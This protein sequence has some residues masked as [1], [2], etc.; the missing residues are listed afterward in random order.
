M[1][2]PRKRASSLL[3]QLPIVFTVEG[4]I[5]ATA[6]IGISRGHVHVILSEEVRAGRLVRLRRG[7][8]RR[9][10]KVVDPYAIGSRLVEPCAIG[11]WSALHCHGLVRRKPPVVHVVTSRRSVATPA[12][13][14]TGGEGSVW[15]VE[16]IDYEVRTTAAKRFFGVVDMELAGGV[17]RVFEPERAILDLFGLLGRN[18]GILPVLRFLERA[19][20]HLD[21]QRLMTY[22][23]RFGSRALRV[24]LGWALESLGVR[25]LRSLAAPHR[26]VRLNDVSHGQ[27][28]RLDP[29]RP[30]RPRLGR[31]DRWEIH[32]NIAKPWPRGSNGKKKTPRHSI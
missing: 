13:R 11:S 23:H 15:N 16:G 31:D 7:L 2:R 27:S 28:I 22:A 14:D 30:S 18:G 8:Y 17:A 24:R 19:V 1:P 6:G 21:V 5:T 20:A 29:T 4:A 10:G 9:A 26:R 32:I 25:G 3:D 12:M